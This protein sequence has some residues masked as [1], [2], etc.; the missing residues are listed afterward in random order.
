[1]IERNSQ[2]LLR[3]VD[4][5]LDLSKIEAG[6]MV[7]EHIEFS[8]PD[9]LS[10]FASLMGLRARDKG[11]DFALKITS[12]IPALV[13]S[14]PTRFRQILNNI[15]GNAIKF[16][17][18]GQVELSVS[19]EDKFLKIQV[20]DTG[21]GI[22]QEQAD[23]LFQAFVQADET[24]TRKFGGTGLGLVLTKR[25]A[26]AMGG[27]FYLKES[28]LDVGSV[29]IASIK[30][31]IISGTRFV[32]HQTLYFST[33]E[34]AAAA[35]QLSML[36]G[37]K[38]LVVDDSP[39]NR[40]LLSVILQDAGASV[41]SAQDGLQ[42][43]EKALTSSYD[44]VLMDIQMPR[45]DGYQAIEVLKGQG[46]P[47][48][49]IALTAHAMVEER[50]R[51]KGKGFAAFMTKPIQRESLLNLLDGLR[52]KKRPSRSPGTG[53]RS[54][55][56]EVRN[57][58]RGVLIVEDD[59]DASEVMELILAETGQ[60]IKFARDGKTV[61]ELLRKG[62]APSVVLLDLTLPDMPGSDVLKAIRST[63]GCEQ[64]RVIVVSGWDNLDERAKEIGADGALR[65]PVN[66]RELK[67][68]VRLR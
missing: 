54:S 16:T 49:I 33:V 63:P 53:P 44:V 68:L 55:D 27:D 23:R 34:E 48:P 19:Y 11:I 47:A 60:N 26:S 2:H 57:S 9:L 61:L 1:V 28:A 52:R 6:K 17:E 62:F 21:R 30:I 25:L 65:K 8:L 50:E 64:A 31:G 29:F 20:K 59:V 46:Y 38:I 41:D 5:I 39:D 18:R 51:A 56:A 3:I 42:G 32:D 40:T 7:F 67:D 66:I 13:I 22:S 12:P 10:D 4:D 24:T 35:P 58:E 45:M 43:V 36:A 15:V 37:M 14:D